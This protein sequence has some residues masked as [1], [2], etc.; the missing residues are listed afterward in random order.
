M[1][2]MRS[3]TWLFCLV[4]LGC[5]GS[6]MPNVLEVKQSGNKEI[7]I[8]DRA[9]SHKISFGEVTVKRLDQGTEVQVMLQNMTKRDV[10]FE[11]RF[12]WYDAAGFEVSPLTAW[13]P[14]NLSA[15]QGSGFKSTAPTATAVDFKLMIRSPHP[16]TNMT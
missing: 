1:K 9:L 7:E 2:T 12:V 5:A 14:A 16:L 6:T 10:A 15:G 8:N 4:C 3:M 13:I 11:Y